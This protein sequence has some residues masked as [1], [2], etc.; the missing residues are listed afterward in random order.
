MGWFVIATLLA[1]KMMHAQVELTD[2]PRTG[3]IVL[4]PIFANDYHA[5]WSNPANLGL[6]PKTTTFTLG[7]PMEYGEYRI[8]RPLSIGVGEVGATIVSDAMSLRELSTIVFRINEQQ[9]S[10]QEKRQVAERFAG[11]GI[12]LNVD[13]QLLGIAYR[14]AGW[15]GVALGVR[16]RI[17]AEFRFNAMLARIMFLGRLD[18]YFDSTAI[19]WR[20]DT[21]GYA[22]SPK[23]FSE[24][25]DSS[26]IGMTWLRD[27]AVGYGIRLYNGAG[28]QLYG[29]LTARLIQGYILLDGRIENRIMTAYS[30]ISPFFG[31]DYGKATTPS[32][33]PGAGLVPVGSGY[34]VDL[35]LSINIGDSW[36]A[37][38]TMSDLGSV[39]WDGNVFAALDTVLNGMITTGF[40]SFNIFE[41]AQNIT[42]EGG[43]FKWMG[44]AGVRTLLPTRL[45]VAVSHS[46]G[47]ERDLGIEATIPLQASAP[48]SPPFFAAIG[49]RYW[50]N[51]HL[52]VCGG[53][54]VG[55]MAG[56][57]LPLSLQ[58]SLWNGRWEIGIS[59]QDLASLIIPKR[60]VLSLAVALLRFHI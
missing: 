60:P 44:L 10:L 54:R 23:Y 8:E 45:R 50:V 41:Q 57:A 46:V 38:L 20:G 1:V 58:L 49:L 11:G 40:S 7:S 42:G 52:L 48:G 35:G 55:T 24:L 21:V 32:L 33:R 56:W 36:R 5:L 53:I 9:L 2:S 17:S 6:I 16:D 18:S 14:S 19:N 25:F 27:Y 43:Y 59:T 4:A 3:A 22:R 12:A 26:R 39:W 29:G 34:G 28:M 15:G 13:A 47:V 30:A 51:P 31:I 37:A